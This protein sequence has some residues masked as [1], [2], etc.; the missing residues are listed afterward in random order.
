M[1]KEEFV[2]GWL[3]HI[4]RPSYPQKS[5][6]LMNKELDEMILFE[7]KKL[8]QSRQADVSGSL[9][10]QHLIEMLNECRNLLVMCSLID[11][12][13]HCKSLVDKVDLKMGWK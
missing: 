4:K 9:P 6:D 13:G 3:S 10:S 7:S 8:E 12:S 11:K 5:I 1:N 2:N